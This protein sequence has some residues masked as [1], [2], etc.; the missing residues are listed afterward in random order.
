MMKFLGAALL[1]L[2]LSA[3]QNSPSPWYQAYGTT[4]FPVAKE[5]MA[6]LYI[7]RDKAPPDAPSIPISM[8]RHPVGGLT[9]ILL[10]HFH[11][12]HISGIPDLCLTRITCSTDSSTVCLPSRRDVS[13]CLLSFDDNPVTRMQKCICNISLCG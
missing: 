13:S 3:C 5:G 1:A 7:V 8:S 9:G 2:S 10:T 4:S 6:A 11:S 12:D